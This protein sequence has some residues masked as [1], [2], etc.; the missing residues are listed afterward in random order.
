MSSDD[1]QLRAGTGNSCDDRG[2]VEGVGNTADSD[3]RV[4]RGNAGDGVEQPSSGLSTSG[5][6]V[7]AVVVAVVLLVMSRSPPFPNLTYLERVRS[8]L[9]GLVLLA[10]LIKVLASATCST[11]LGYDTDWRAW[12]DTESSVSGSD[13]LAST[14]SS[15]ENVRHGFLIKMWAPRTG[16]PRYQ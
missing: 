7:V 2:L 4:G 6:S 5:G 10:R 1:N 9:W 11:R 16:V 12:I 15:Y 14:V 3:G 8:Q 13:S